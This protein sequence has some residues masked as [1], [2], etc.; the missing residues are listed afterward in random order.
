MDEVSSPRERR[1]RDP[2]HSERGGYMEMLFA[3]VHFGRSRSPVVTLGVISLAHGCRTCSAG[4]WFVW[5]RELVRGRFGCLAD[6]L[7]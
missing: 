4:G 5:L 1:P 6:T 7:T 3:T 2:R